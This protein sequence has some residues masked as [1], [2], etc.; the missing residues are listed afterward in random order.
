VNEKT[1]S[2]D[3]QAS[4]MIP[5]DGGTPVVSSLDGQIFVFDLGDEGKWWVRQG[6]EYQ[7]ASTEQQQRCQQLV[8]TYLDTNYHDLLP[9][10]I[11]LLKRLLA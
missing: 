2:L 11:D 6:H 8:L 3:K 1:I 4:V 10:Q 5:L 9:I 7:L